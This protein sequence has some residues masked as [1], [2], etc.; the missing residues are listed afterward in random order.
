[1]RPQRPL[2][3]ESPVTPLGLTQARL[4]WEKTYREAEE[5][6]TQLAGILAACQA[7]LLRLEVLKQ[8]RQAQ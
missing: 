2:P 8:A 7:T 4:Q 6:L 3:P 1:M 5:A